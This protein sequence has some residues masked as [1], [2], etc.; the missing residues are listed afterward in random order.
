MG[1]ADTAQAV[2]SRLTAG[3]AAVDQEIYS[4]AEAGCLA[5]QEDG[6][7]DQFVDGGHSAQ[8]RIGLELGDLFGNFGAQVSSA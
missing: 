1:H 7:P 5:E 4:G 2:P 6:R 8:R 3:E